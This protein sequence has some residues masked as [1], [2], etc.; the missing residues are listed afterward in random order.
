M[1]SIGETLRQERVRRNLDLDRISKD[2]K[3]SP[4]MLTAIEAD[5]FDQLPGGVFTKSFVRQYARHLEL[6]EDEIGRELQ[7]VLEPPTPAAPSSSHSAPAE[8]IHVP[9]VK[10][11]DSVG[12]APRFQWGSPLKSLGLVVLVTLACS[13]VY[14]WWQRERKAPRAHPTVLAKQTAPALPAAA[15]PPPPVTPIAANA[16]TTAPAPAPEPAGAQSADAKPEQPSAERQVAAPAVPESNPNPSGP[17]QVQVTAVEPVWVLVR[18]DG[19]YSFSGTLDTNQTRTIGANE[20]VTLRVGNAGGLTISLNGK[21]VGAIGNKGDVRTVQFTSGGFH[22]V[23]PEVPK[24]VSPTGPD[25][26]L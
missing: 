26:P 10:R 16:E 18:A 19:K 11:W 8:P 13:S 3:I 21:P 5:R 17:V 25:D 6:D 20:N 7:Q 22:I 2:L 23:P 24:P 1:M 15:A 4:R 14:T 9:R 12:D